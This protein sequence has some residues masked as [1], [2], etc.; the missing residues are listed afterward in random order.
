[1]DQLVFMNIINWYQITW[2]ICGFSR[3]IL[4]NVA[5][6]HWTHILQE[7]DIILG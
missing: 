7:L 6:Y 4:E 3:K 2:D 1:M 5:F